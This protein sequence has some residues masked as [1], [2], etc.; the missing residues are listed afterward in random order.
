MHVKFD[1]QAM[2]RCRGITE[3][4]KQCSITSSSNW[5]DNNGSLVGEPLYR[6]GEFC[7][8]HAKPFCTKPTQINDFGRL[9]IFMLDLETTGTDVSQDMINIKL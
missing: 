5:V 3:A 9:V 6:G 7:S 2:I 4:R 8:V 1:A